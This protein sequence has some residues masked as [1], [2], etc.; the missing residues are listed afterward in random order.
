[1]MMSIRM[2]I[3]MTKPYVYDDDIDDD[4]AHKNAT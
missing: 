2:M 3:P 1:M 4:N